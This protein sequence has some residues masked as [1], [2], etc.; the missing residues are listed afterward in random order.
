MKFKKTLFIV[1]A[2]LFTLHAFAQNITSNLIG[3]WQTEDKTIVEIYKSGNT[4]GI[5]QISAVK[6]KD[7]KNNGKVIGKNLLA[8]NATECNG[9]LIDPSDNKEYKAVFIVA[10]DGKTLKLKVKWGLLSFNEK[11]KKQ[12]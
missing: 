6:E 3:T 1:L 7:K 5:K 12:S 8:I 2:T 10:P 11:W 4:I 9:I